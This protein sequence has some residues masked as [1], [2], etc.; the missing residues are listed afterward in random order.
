MNYEMA[1]AEASKEQGIDDICSALEAIGI[2]ATSA[3]TGG[4]TM[5]AYIELE[6][7]KYIYANKFGASLYDADGYTASL[8]QYDEPQSAEQIAID[9]RNIQSKKSNLIQ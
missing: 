2:K 6:G 8:F 5:C 3:Q 4:F 7:D 1:T 9:L